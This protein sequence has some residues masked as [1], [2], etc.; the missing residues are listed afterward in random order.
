MHVLYSPIS[1][2]KEPFKGHVGVSYV[3]TVG[4][5]THRLKKAL[6]HAVDAA[7]MAETHPDVLALHFSRVQGSKA[8][9]D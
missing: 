2:L 9:S 6:Q 1:P 8:P 5:G 7:G 3:C 4:T